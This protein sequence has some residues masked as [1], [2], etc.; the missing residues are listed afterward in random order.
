MAG[1]A[2]SSIFGQFTSERPVSKR[3]DLGYNLVR[4]HRVLQ[5]DS[6]SNLDGSSKGKE[7]PY[8]DACPQLIVQ[9]VAAEEG[10][11][12]IQT[13]R[14]NGLGYYRPED[15]DAQTM[16]DNDMVEGNGY[17]MVEKDGQYV[18]V[19]H[20]GR[21]EDCRNILNQFFAALN[22]EEGST[23]EDVQPGLELVVYVEEEEY[24]GKIQRNIKSFRKAETYVPAEEGLE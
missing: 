13:H 7:R 11:S 14:F 9:F 16:K 2:I 12:G 10:K 19:A 8:A 15:F 1:K 4:V 17:V 23:L 20:E 5:G 6:N 3:L 18:R 21:T 22:L 24:E